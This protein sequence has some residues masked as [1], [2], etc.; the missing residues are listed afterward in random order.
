MRVFFDASVIIASLLSPTGGSSLLFR[1]VKTG[2]FTGIISQTVIGEITAKK[3]SKKIK[4]TK[5]EIEEW[6]A[7]SGLIVRKSITTAEIKIYQD[8]IDT[9]DAHLVAGAR[10]T[11][12]SRLVTLDKKHLLNTDI[13]Q[14]FLP[15]RIVSP[16]ELLQ[17]IIKIKHC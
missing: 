10:L 11:H 16:K 3:K 6:I 4:K 15:I 9:D 5:T 17:E 7:G 12:C 14:R 1:Y 2:Q 8:M 13:T